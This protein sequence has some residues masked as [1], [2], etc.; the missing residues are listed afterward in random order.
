MKFTAVNESR[1]ARKNHVMLTN[2]HTYIH[3]DTGEINASSRELLAIC[4]RN[5]RVI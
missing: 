4:P 1:L 2:I 3:T 5:S